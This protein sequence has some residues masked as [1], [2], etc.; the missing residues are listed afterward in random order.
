MGQVRG[1]GI[2]RIGMVKGDAILPAIRA[3]LDA[4][5]AAPHPR[6][7]PWRVDGETLGWID[8]GRVRESG[9]RRR[10]RRH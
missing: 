9:F 7:R 5:L 2:G 4:A 8:D 1:S 10:V 6:Y 3:R